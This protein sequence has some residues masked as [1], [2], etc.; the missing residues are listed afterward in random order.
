MILPAIDAHLHFWD[1]RRSDHRRLSAE[2]AP[3]GRPFGPDD[4][5]PELELEGMTGAILVQ[6]STSTAETAELLAARRTRCPS[7]SASWAGPTSRLRTS[8]D[9]IDALRAGPG[10]HHLVGLSHRVDDEDDP[11]WLARDDV[12]RGLATL[13]AKGLALDVAVRTRELP[14]TLEVGTAP[15][16]TSRVVL[17]HLAR[18][19]IA[20]GDLAAWGRALLALAE[21]PNVVA[22]LSGLVTEADWHTWSID[23]L[24]HPVE[25]AVDA[26]GAER[27]MLGLGL[28]TLPAGWLLWRRHRLRALPGGRAVG[29]RAGRDRRP[30]GHARLP[31]GAG[32]S[33]SPRERGRPR[34]ARSSSPTT[35]APAAT[36]P[37]S[38]PPTAACWRRARAPYATDFG[39][40]GKAE[41][42]PAD[43]WAAFCAATRTLLEETGTRPVGH[44][45]RGHVRPDDGRGA[46]GR[47]R[48]GAAARPSSGPTR[49]P[50]G[51]P[52]CSPSG[53]ASSAPTSCWGIASTR[54]TACPSGCG[55]A[56]TSRRPGRRRPACSWPRTPSR[57]ASPDGAAPTRPTPPAPTPGTRRPVP[58]R[59]RCWR[60]ASIDAGLLP[61]VV[62]SATVAGGIR[63]GGRTG[64]RAAGGHAGRGRGRGWLLRRAGCRPAR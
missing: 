57:C 42:D 15:C 9:V 12:R 27:L 38:T 13:A 51:K 61:E 28:A 56:S 30:H 24:R 32:S 39:P 3:L 2:L 43:W 19:P 6:A 55:C 14:A 29:S 35:W 31:P 5:R 63:D 45:L 52:V 64:L 36:R 8:A 18:P 50:S 22:K 26:F 16:L 48:R 46:G 41:Q 20:S 40:G 53:S 49:A 1:P 4:L 25:L 44:R 10:G 37:R 47:P 23:D 59:T 33:V 54:P 58:G 34:A 11:A 17:H 7:C 62:P 60:P 21:L